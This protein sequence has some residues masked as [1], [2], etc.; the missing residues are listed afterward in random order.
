MKSTH[1]LLN[2]VEKTYLNGNLDEE[3]TRIIRKMHEIELHK[4]TEKKKVEY[5][6]EAI[7]MNNPK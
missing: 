2:Y 5:G 1:L 3:T 6:F 7:F 4:P